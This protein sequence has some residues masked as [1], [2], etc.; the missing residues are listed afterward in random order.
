VLSCNFSGQT[1]ERAS[2]H[3]NSYLGEKNLNTEA[4]FGAVL[5]VMWPI[6]ISV[7]GNINFTFIVYNTI[8]T[9]IEYCVYFC[10]YFGVLVSDKSFP[11]YDGTYRLHKILELA[12]RIL[13]ENFMHPFS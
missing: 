1:Q 3:T 2:L 7:Y 6:D 5:N 10:I 8:K 9:Y 12:L 11:K 13:V 4:V